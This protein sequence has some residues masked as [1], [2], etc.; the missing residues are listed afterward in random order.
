MIGAASCCSSRAQLSVSRIV[1]FVS[2]GAAFSIS[3]AAYGEPTQ[4]KPPP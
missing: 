1:T 3:T 2:V 4:L